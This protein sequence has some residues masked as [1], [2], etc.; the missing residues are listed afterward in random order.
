MEEPVLT[1]EANGRFVII[2]V[3][4]DVSPGS[5]PDTE[6]RLGPS[7]TSGAEGTSRHML[8]SISMETHHAPG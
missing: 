6:Q 2:V 7:W 4:V 8:G 1:G 3:G 5:G